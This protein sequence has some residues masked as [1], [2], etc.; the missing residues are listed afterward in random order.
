M[1]LLSVLF[2]LALLVVVFL[3]GRLAG[4]APV[5]ALAAMLMV[6]QRIT[7]RVSSNRAFCY[8]IALASIATTSPYQYSDSSRGSC[9]NVASA[10]G[11]QGARISALVSLSD[12]RA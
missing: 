12:A 3:A 11:A 10:S 7:G 4:G 9:S 5:G 2:G 6:T 1:R 8:S